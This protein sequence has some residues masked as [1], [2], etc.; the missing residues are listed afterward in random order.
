M[1]TRDLTKSACV[2]PAAAADGCSAIW[3]LRLLSAILWTR[4]APGQAR[5][6]LASRATCGRLIFNPG[7]KNRVCH[8]VPSVP[9]RKHMMVTF[10]LEV[11]TVWHVSMACALLL[12]GFRKES[13]AA[14]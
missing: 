3:Q 11:M 13:R 8:K 6:S 5:Q 9:W 7:K 1:S 14:R 12:L 10:G 2:M 4:A